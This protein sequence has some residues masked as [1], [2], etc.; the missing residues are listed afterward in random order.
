MRTAALLVG[1]NYTTDP[2]NRLNGCIND[3]TNM[4]RLLMTK[5]NFVPNDIRILIDTPN[6]RATRKAAIIQALNTLKLASINRNLDLVY[7]HYSGHGSQQRDQ[8]AEETDGLDEGLCPIDFASAGLITDD[9]LAAVFSQFNP[10]T[11][12]IVVTDCCHSGSILDLPCNYNSDGESNQISQLKPS[13]HPNMI[14]LSGC[15]DADT[16]ADAWDP[17]VRKA[18][19]ALTMCLMKALTANPDQS[20]FAIYERTVAYLKQGNYSQRPVLSSSQP[21]SAQTQLF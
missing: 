13:T 5:Y 3:V 20:L 15:V 7:F 1:I 6:P 2:L 16:S 4:A 19:G 8:N 11:R 14:C 21:L 9:E 10:R 12:I 17:E 18:G